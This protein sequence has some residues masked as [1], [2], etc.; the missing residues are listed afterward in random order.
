M[1]KQT[2]APR[3]EM[4]LTGAREV[5][6]PL[7][8]RAFYQEV[9]EAREALTGA[10]K[11]LTER[12]VNT[13]LKAGDDAAGILAV[14]DSLTADALAKY[15]AAHPKM[16][17]HTVKAAM[18]ETTGTGTAFQY[19]SYIR[20]ILRVKGMEG[21]KGGKLASQYAK[22]RKDAKAK[23]ETE[24][25]AQADATKSVGELDTVNAA[26]NGLAAMLRTLPVDVAQNIVLRAIKEARE[27]REQAGNGQEQVAEADQRDAA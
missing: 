25:K 10:S 12:M 21:L 14:L 23:G 19:L 7:F 3:N 24:E 11:G 26:M 6:A 2:K 1:A 18:A 5:L 15:K 17:N 8:D 9:R 22:C 4:N 27:A 16:A 20:T 13:V